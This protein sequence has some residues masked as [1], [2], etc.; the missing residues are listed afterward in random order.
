MVVR[1]G[2]SLLCLC[3]HI[4]LGASPPAP[5]LLS[6][7]LISAGVCER[8][9]RERRVGFCCH[10]HCCL[11]RLLHPARVKRI[12]EA[13]NP[14]PSSTSSTSTSDSSSDESGSPALASTATTPPIPTDGLTL[15]DVQ[16]RVK[17]ASGRSATLKCQ[18]LDKFGSWKWATSKFAHQSRAAPGQVLRQ[19]ASKFAE[20][21]DPEGL[22]EIETALALHPD[23]PVGPP[24]VSPAHAPISASLRPGSAPP[25]AHDLP[26][27]S[28]L[29]RCRSDSFW[30]GQASPTQRTIPNSR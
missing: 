9:E 14:G 11:Q 21:L 20:E 2:M 7:S 12:G 24:G 10:R 17:M 25:T 19:W 15:P 6:L 22:A 13:S 18:W 29:E 3:L 1:P 26:P 30:L 16:L 27:A 4:V 28:E 23:P 8:N 5:L